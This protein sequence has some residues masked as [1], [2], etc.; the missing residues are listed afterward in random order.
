MKIFTI[1]N[2]P[3]YGTPLTAIRKQ[4]VSCIHVYIIHIWTSNRVMGN[5]I[6]RKFSED[7]SVAEYLCNKKISYSNYIPFRPILKGFVVDSTV[8][9]QVH[10]Y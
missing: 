10:I 1:E 9:V 3:I 6:K 5:Y 2:F 7:N 4:I 8:H